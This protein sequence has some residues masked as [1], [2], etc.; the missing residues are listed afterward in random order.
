MTTPTVKT[1]GLKVSVQDSNGSPILRTN[2]Q[3]PTGT[4]N[5]VA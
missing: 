5:S 2:G 3:S 4:D 1:R